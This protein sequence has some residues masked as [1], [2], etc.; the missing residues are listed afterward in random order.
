[1]S[2][3]FLTLPSL[4]V[5]ALFALA[6]PVHAKTN[7]SAILAPPLPFAVLK[8]VPDRDLQ[9]RANPA[10]QEIEFCWSHCGGCG[11]YAGSYPSWGWGYHYYPY[12]AYYYPYWG[13][14]WP[15]YYAWWGWPYYYGWYSPS[16]AYYWWQYPWWSNPYSTYYW[17]Y[18][19]AVSLAVPVEKTRVRVAGA[20][21]SL[22]SDGVTAYWDHDYARACDGFLAAVLA[23]P[24]DARFWYYR[25][26]AERAA[27]RSSE[28]EESVRRGAALEVLQTPNSSQIALSLER[29]QGLD[30][31]FLHSA[32]TPDLTVER[33]EQIAS[34]PVRRPSEIVRSK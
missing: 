5:L 20:P 19:Q 6:V 17:W 21:D 26:L 24:R 28:A 2:S 7:A 22:F 29:I 23:N 32:V 11:D 18:S 34:Q 9:A 31:R 13:Y 27:G 1:M 3:R 8:Q 15:S 25:A 10:M 30:R 16:Y 14:Y 33:A 4:A 12:W